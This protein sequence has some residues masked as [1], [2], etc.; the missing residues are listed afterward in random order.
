MDEL[1]LYGIAS[2]GSL[3][4]SQ[5]HGLAG[6]VSVLEHGGIGAIV[7]TPPKDGFQE[8]SRERALRLLLGHQEVL[9]AAMVKATVLPV[10]FGTVAPHEG[11]VLK[12]LHQR[13]DMLTELL[14]KFS[15]C[16]QVEIV[17]L[18][19]P[20]SIFAEIA[21]EFEIL[22]AR[23]AAEATAGPAAAVQLGQMV[24][25]ALERRR[26][27]LQARL[28][29][30]LSPLAAGI[31][32]NAPMDDRMAANLAVL[33]GDADAERLQAQLEKLD[34]EF[35]G[36]LTIRCVGPLPPASFATLQ[37][38]FPSAQAIDRARQILGLPGRAPSSQEAVASAFRR[39][40]RE[41]H[42]D[43]A[44]PAEESA[45]R[46]GELTAAYKLLLSCIKAQEQAAPGA[47]AGEPVLI[48]IIGRKSDEPQMRQR[49]AE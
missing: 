12:L 21:G 25:A 33:I 19:Q 41:N 37:V 35:S 9:E 1:Y 2:A 17:V 38:G 23:K 45:K 42:P 29:Q 48:E 40:A 11:A 6:G 28:Y 15:G 20:E 13:R 18:W 3:S 24:K 10:K 39:L 16:T 46:M 8:L 36:Q 31:A 7:G 5:I 27:R 4:L 47:D 34:A 43:L 26:G 44:A 22:E 30:A 32:F 49:V 14:T